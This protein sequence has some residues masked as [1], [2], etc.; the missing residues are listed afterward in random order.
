M[1]QNLKLVQKTVIVSF[2]VFCFSILF[3]SLSFCGVISEGDAKWKEYKNQ[4]FVIYYKEAPLDFVKTVG[5][6][7]EEYYSE[8]TRNL[9]FTR[10]KGWTWD[11]RA[12]IYIYDSNEDYVESA[13]TYRWSGGIASP[14]FKII[15][16][17][18]AARGF[19]DSTLPHELGHIIFREFV[20]FKAQIPNWFEEG[21][22][23]YQ[24]KAKRWGAHDIVRK[25]IKNETFM[26]L[27]DLA[28]IKLNNETEQATVSLFYAESASIVSYMINELGE[29]R[30]ERF[31]REL[32]EGKSFDETLEKVYVRFQDTKK[33]NNVWVGYLNR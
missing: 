19:F 27:D 24:E 9:G 7:A 1:H 12:K 4:H 10:Y 20:G 21:I 6:S 15:R 18:P 30:F 13:R 32:K 22:A 23:M 28:G 16:T 26:T 31:C 3:C 29:F 17:F 33:L 8:I 25:A 5:K 11:R 14:M 2:F